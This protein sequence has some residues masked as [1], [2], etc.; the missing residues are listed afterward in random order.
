MDILHVS[1]GK[2][3]EGC[4]TFKLNVTAGIYFL[5]AGVASTIGG[6]M[7]YLYRLVDACMLRMLAHNDRQMLGIAYIEPEFSYQILPLDPTFSGE[8][9]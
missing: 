1:A 4:F 7:T 2:L 8:S 6:E 3:V 9:E 5:N